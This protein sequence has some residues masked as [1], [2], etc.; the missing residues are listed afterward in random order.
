M[1][2][3]KDV[4]VFRK[5]LESG[6]QSPQNLAGNMVMAAFLQAGM[7]AGE[8]FILGY[9]SNHPWKEQILTLH[10]WFTSIL[11]SL[12]L[13]YSIPAVYRKSEKVQYLVS[14]LVSQ[15]LF[16]ITFYLCALFVAAEG[17]GVPDHSMVAFTLTSLLT[18][19]LVFFL[20]LL[21]LILKIR[22]G[23]YREG[24]RQDMW[25][26]TFEYK[27]YVPAATAA[28]LGIFF[29]L[30]YVIRQNGWTDLGSLGF[31]VIGFGLFY[32]MMF[33]LPEQLVIF[34]CKFRF[35]EFHLT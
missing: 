18:G 23:D 17:A 20:V 29:I 12:S 27:S 13:L 21:R 14:I 33:V 9:T 28:G 4:Y 5:P 35:S 16:G 25:R 31:L 3:E 30:Q 34:Y 22:R 24:G 6:R 8:Y 2:Q 32:A 11:I 15:N 26:E 10:F 7:F 1:L 19:L